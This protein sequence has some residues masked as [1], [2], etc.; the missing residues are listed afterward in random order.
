MPQQADR[1]RA[2]ALA[3]LDTDAERAF[4]DIVYIAAQTC[5]APIAL[6]S[7]LDRQRQW[8]KSSSGLPFGP[9]TKTLVVR[10]AA[11]ISIC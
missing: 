10:F 8:F 6:V 7:V 5:D 9:F 1:E 3:V 2:D 4:D 11:A